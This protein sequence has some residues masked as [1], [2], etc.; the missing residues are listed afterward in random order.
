MYVDFT[1]P[2]TELGTGT[3]ARRGNSDIWVFLKPLHANL[4][5]TSAAF[6]VLMGLVVWTIEHPTNEEFQGSV[7]YQIGTILWFGFSTL[8]YAHSKPSTSIT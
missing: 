1:L 6:F 7:A 4:W 8:V 5:L 3:V 2:F